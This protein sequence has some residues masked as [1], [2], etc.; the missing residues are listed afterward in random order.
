MKKVFFALLALSILWGCSSK[1]PT[2]TAITPYENSVKLATKPF[3]PSE[4]IFF[5]EGS[6]IA[7]E[8]I[9]FDDSLR[10]FAEK[11]TGIII[12]GKVDCAYCQSALPVLND[13]ALSQG[14]PA[15][16]VDIYGEEVNDEQINALMQH[17]EP[18]LK[19]VDGQPVMYVPEVV[20]LKD[21]QIVGNHLSLV[22]S[23]NA[24]QQYA[25]SDEQKMELQDIYIDLI[26]K[27]Y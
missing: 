14:V 11:G 19:V 24:S 21:G 10:M 20:A 15:Y 16:Y 3:D 25:M 1:Q 23:F 22:D 6:D 12:W 2:S 26:K 5:K 17:L 7:I 9:S 13:A 18:I 8:K 4:Y 27:L